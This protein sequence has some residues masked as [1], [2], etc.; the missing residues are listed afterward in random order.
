MESPE[1]EELLELL[2]REELLE[3]PERDE[4]LEPLTRLELP[5]LEVPVREELS[6]LGRLTELEPESVRFVEELLLVRPELLLLVVV[7][8]VLGRVVAPEVLEPW[9][10]LGRVTVALLLVFDDPLLLGLE[11]MLPGVLAPEGRT[12]VAFDEPELLGVA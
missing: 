8:V 2:E 12:T 7:V 1:R 5:L 9:F 6:L 11:L 10:P 4:L 3:L